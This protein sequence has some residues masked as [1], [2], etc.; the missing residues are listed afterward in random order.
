MAVANYRCRAPFGPAKGPY[1]SKGALQ[2]RWCRTWFG[3]FQGIV[4]LGYCTRIDRKLRYSPKDLWGN[5]AWGTISLAG[6]KLS[7]SLN[8]KNS[9]VWNPSFPGKRVHFK[10]KGKLISETMYFLRGKIFALREY[11]AT[12]PSEG[13]VLPQM[14]FYTPLN[15][16]CTIQIFLENIS[17]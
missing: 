8:H 1:C 5:V 16:F 15:I 2:G 12:F 11:L 9:L 13:K 7:C 14:M 17:M 6:G 10:G 3:Y 4:L